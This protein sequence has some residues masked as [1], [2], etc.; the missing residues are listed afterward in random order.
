[1]TVRELLGKTQAQIVAQSGFGRVT[2]HEILY[3]LHVAGISTEKNAL[4]D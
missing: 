1:V 3:A 2:L 4:V